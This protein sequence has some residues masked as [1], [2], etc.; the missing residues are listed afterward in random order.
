MNSTSNWLLHDHHKYDMT[1]DEC[2]AAAD[3]GE[4]KK[5]KRLF[6]DFVTDLKL[7]MRMEDEVLYPLFVAD[8]GDP[9]GLI[10]HLSDEHDY[11]VRLVQDL[12][13]IINANNF[14]HFLDSLPPLH[15]AMNLHNKHE[16]QVFLNMTNPSILMRREEIMQRLHAIQ[17]KQGSRNWDF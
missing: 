12:M 17:D 7:H 8:N 6:K 4:W 11:L 10:T 1:L 13:S 14:D 3:T 16:E 2:E 5:A 15:Q 9:E